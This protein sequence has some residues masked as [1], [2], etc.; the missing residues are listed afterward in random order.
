MT[1][2]PKRPA[3]TPVAVEVLVR[4]LLI[5]VGAMT[6]GCASSRLQTR[7]VSVTPAE[8]MQWLEAAVAGSSD[9]LEIVRGA[10]VPR[11][12][13]GAN[14]V[15]SLAIQ[16]DAWYGVGDDRWELS[17]ANASSN[18]NADSTSTM[19]PA[20]SSQNIREELARIGVRNCALDVNR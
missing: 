1:G 9:L 16:I 13:P 6:S 7:A 2:S 18:G 14:I 15:C 10:Y 5:L 20:R 3:G 11:G 19:R 4:T 12:T 8:R 17:H